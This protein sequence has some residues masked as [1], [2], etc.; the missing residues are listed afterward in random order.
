MVRSSPGNYADDLEDLNSVITVN[1]LAPLYLSRS[2][3]RHWLG[4]P[5]SVT[6]GS[7]EKGKREETVNLNKRILMISS[8]SGLVNMTPQ[9]Q[10]AYNASKGGLTMAAKVCPTPSSCYKANRQSLAGE[11]AGYGISVNCISPG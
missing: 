11:W 5:A 7:E 6:S 10:V 1:L 2:L 3:V 8:I 9:K 4:L